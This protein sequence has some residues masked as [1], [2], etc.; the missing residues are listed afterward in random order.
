MVEFE[1]FDD[2]IEARGNSILVL[3]DA[4]ARFSEEHRQRVREALAEYGITDPETAEWYPQHAELK[5]FETI[6][7]ELEPHILDRL[8]EQ[9]PVAADW[10]DDIDGVEEALR[11]INNAYELNHRGGEI[12]HYEF[13][14]TGDRKGK[15][16]CKNPYPCRFDR[17]LIRGVAQAHSPVESFV[18]LEER[19]DNCRRR[20]DD[21]C[22]YTVHW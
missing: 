3:E 17:G 22:T 10:P 16:E 13:E 19:G 4:L 20:G 18:F 15:I 21:T 11:S 14:K 9:V 2:G 5:A 7:N 6:A 12:G 1:P 8:G